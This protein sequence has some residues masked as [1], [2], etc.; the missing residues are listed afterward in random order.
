[1]FEDLGINKNFCFTGTVIE[2]LAYA[3]DLI[4]HKS[5]TTKS[6]GIII[7]TT[8]PEPTLMEHLEENIA[9]NPSFEETNGD[10][11]DWNNVTDVNLCTSTDAVQP[12]QWNS[13]TDSCVAV[14][15]SDKNV[16][17]DGRY[18]VFVK[19][20]ISQPLENLKIGQLC[21]ITFVTAHPPILGAVLANKEGYVQIG[22][23][24]HVFMVYTK[25]DKHGSNSDEVD[26][27]HHTFYFRS[28]IYKASI[29]FGSMTGNTGILFDDIKVQQAILHDHDDNE[30]QGK[31]I[32]AHV[33][34]LHQWSSIHAS[35]SFVDPESP[36][37]DYMWAIGNI[38]VMLMLR[39]YLF[40]TLYST[41]LK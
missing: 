21:R 16:A 37:V 7:D 34:A 35:W 25:H 22:D 30:A 26:W 27:H 11:I 15:K 18:F 28:N 2:S 14:L 5:K 10:T 39:K 1:M 40:L 3:V 36:I 33:V 41:E 32:H 19:G 38:Y 20:Q 24:R 13:T 8:H 12:I 31:H 23:K 4:G 6:N 17:M 9:I 29:S